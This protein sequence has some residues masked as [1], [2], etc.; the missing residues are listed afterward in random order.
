ML[1]IKLLTF[2]VIYSWR[3]S[4]SPLV[5]AYLAKPSGADIFVNMALFP[6]DDSSPELQCEMTSRHTPQQ[7][8]GLCL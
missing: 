4:R 3:S 7:R 8:H 2:M 6:N 5:K 1:R